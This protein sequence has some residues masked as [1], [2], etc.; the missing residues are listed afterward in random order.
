MDSPLNQSLRYPEEPGYTLMN[1]RYFPIFRAA[2]A[3]VAGGVLLIPATA[4][5][6]STAVA[7]V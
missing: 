3:L 1:L 2:S 6:Q 5:A 4:L 7:D